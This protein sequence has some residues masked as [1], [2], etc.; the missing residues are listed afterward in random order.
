MS[1]YPSHMRSVS[2]WLLCLAL[3][4]ACIAQTSLKT[5]VQD[6][7]VNDALDSTVVAWPAPET[8]LADIR[9]PDDQKRLHA[10]I[11]LGVDQV[12]QSKV[13]PE[14]DGAMLRYVQLANPTDDQQAVLTAQI[15]YVYEYVAIATKKNGSWSRIGTASCWCKYER[16]DLLANFAHVEFAPANADPELV[17]HSSGGGTG[18][19]EQSELRYR[20]RNNKL[21][22]VAA[23]LSREMSCPVGARLT[24]YCTLRRRWLSDSV[25]PQ[26]TAILV[27]AHATV[28]SSSPRPPITAWIRDLDGMEFRHLTCIGFRWN[29]KAFRYDAAPL[30]PNPCLIQPPK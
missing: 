23:F 12:Q 7:E 17:I 16:G 14:V 21:I 2:F 26:N 18:L 9:S 4:P 8:V 6:S 29:E 1:Y 11:I 28:Y 24:P 25:D 5:L 22:L 13:V 20:L 10:L 30:K 3:I 15:G 19:Y 27:E